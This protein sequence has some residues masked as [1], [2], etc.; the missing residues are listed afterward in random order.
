MSK[1]YIVVERTFSYNDETYSQEEGGTPKTVFLDKKEADEKALDLNIK[2]LKS[3]DSDELRM[4]CYDIQDLMDYDKRRTSM[5]DFE[6]IV[7]SDCYDDEGWSL[8]HDRLTRDDY[9]KLLKILV[10]LN[11][12]YV[13]PADLKE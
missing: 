11:F 4:Y 3:L 12:Y 5:K 9:E 1:A 8:P 10:H 2:K 7:G 6:T 13:V